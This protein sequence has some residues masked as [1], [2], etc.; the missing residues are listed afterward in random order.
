MKQDSLLSVLI[1]RRGFWAT[2]ILIYANI[3]I[4]LLMVIDGV[5]IFMPDSLGL[6][7][8][9]AD[10]GPLTL[11]GDWWRTF[12]CN[13]VH[14]GILHLIMNMYALLFICVWLEPL[15]GTRRM[16]FAYILTGLCSTLASLFMHNDLISAGAS[17]A[18]FG[19]Y[20]IFLA[21]LFSNLVE[22]NQ[23]P[24]LFASILVFVS[25]SL[26]NGI[27]DGVDN[28]AHVGGLIG[29]IVLGY[30]YVFAHKQEKTLSK[31]IIILSGEAGIILLF[32]V[33]FLCLSSNIPG[34]Y[35]DIRTSWKQ[36]IIQAY[37]SGEITDEELEEMKWIQFED[38]ENHFTCRY[39]SNWTKIDN[40]RL[41]RSD[42]TVPLLKL[43]NG[44]NSF[45]A[46]R[47]NFRTAAELERNK[48]HSQRIPW[49]NEPVFQLSDIEINGVPFLKKTQTLQIGGTGE[50]GY[51]LNQVTLFYYPDTEEL[52]MLRI[53][54]RY[55]DEQAKED[56]MK[57]AETIRL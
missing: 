44:N 30:V 36:G 56:L 1:P 28:A 20:G 12:S 49:G 19:L 35:E 26:L 33:G 11:T 45:T 57:M 23:R 53:I 17:G 43:V 50:A 38:T 34:D 15:I 55:T 13:F 10:F 16:F 22:K 8:W 48:K 7:Q 2:G 47:N 6:L 5:G 42:K 51:E 24:A 21:F 46:V 40:S 41:L 4:F 29:G 39:L 37:L 18:I 32:L 3:L 52:Y 9:G 54:M 25:Y 14:I 27:Q 31:R